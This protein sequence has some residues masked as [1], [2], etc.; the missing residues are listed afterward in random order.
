M[1]VFYSVNSPTAKRVYHKPGCIYERRIKDANRTSVS[2]ETAERKGYHE[3]RYCAGRE[4][5]VGA[6]SSEVIRWKFR[7][8]VEIIYEQRTDTSF[9]ITENSVWKIFLN[10]RGKY[11][12]FHMNK[13][14]KGMSFYEIKRAAYH[15]QSDV[16]ATDSFGKI[17]H[18]IIEH[19][20]AKQIIMDDYR[21]LPQKTKK[22]R[23]Y[24]RQAERKH[25]H[26][27]R[28]RIDAVFAS[29]ERRNPELKQYSIC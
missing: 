22:Q 29:L 23:K 6:D 28:F 20:K 8:N 10:R 15:C 19:D 25:K 14:S 17:I 24:Y 5:R 4:G 9:V 27:Q 12:L 7:E 18:Y 2:K 21:K 3:C 16:K 1:Q 13:Y 26:K 11:V